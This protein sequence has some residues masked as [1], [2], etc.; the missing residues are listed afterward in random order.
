MGTWFLLF[1]FL[2]VLAFQKSNDVIYITHVTPARLFSINNQIEQN[3][4][5]V[6][7]RTLRHS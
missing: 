5:M 1:N 6:N 3:I 7:H 4:S 2:A